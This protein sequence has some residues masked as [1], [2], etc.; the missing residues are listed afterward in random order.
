MLEQ[1]RPF[2]GDRLALSLINREQVK[3]NGFKVSE[4][5]GVII[6]DDARKTVLK[7]YQKRKQEEIMQPF[8]KEKVKIGL[9]FYIQ[10]LLLARYLRHDLDGY[11]VFIWK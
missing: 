5:G 6:D 4:T 2:L 11:P 3:K 8:I 10:A 1:F 7:A 9:L